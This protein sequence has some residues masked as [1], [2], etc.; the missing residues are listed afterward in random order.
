MVAEL[1]V[2]VLDDA[3]ESPTDRPTAAS[4]T[5]QH[6]RSR[7]RPLPKMRSLPPKWWS[8]FVKYWFPVVGLAI[9]ERA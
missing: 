9:R 3:D 4:G 7:R 6:P 1:S 5:R 8:I 2:P